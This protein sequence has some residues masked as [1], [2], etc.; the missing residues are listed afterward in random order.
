MRRRVMN[1]RILRMPVNSGGGI[2]RDDMRTFTSSSTQASRHSCVKLL[3]ERTGLS[4]SSNP[5]HCYFRSLASTQPILLQS[6]RTM[7]SQSVQ[8]HP[9]TR[10]RDARTIMEN[11]AVVETSSTGGCASQGVEL[12]VRRFPYNL[13]FPA[14]RAF[15]F[16][17]SRT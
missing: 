11:I 7:A 8:V 2:V 10:S 1:V 4:Q 5:S 12:E 9:T 3:D 15:R 17:A 6:S 14:C 16:L 13:S